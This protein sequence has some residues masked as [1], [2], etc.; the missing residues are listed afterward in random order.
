MKH[1]LLAFLLLTPL[2]A[3][4]LD[5]PG[6]TCG[7]LSADR[8]TLVERG[9]ATAV[10]TDD[11]DDAG[12]LIAADNLRADFRRTGATAV[13]TA[14]RAVIAGTLASKYIRAL[15]KAKKINAKDL[16]GKREKYVI[17]FVKSP[18]A[19]I[20]EALVI[21]GSDKRG[22]IYGIYEL[23]EQLGVSPWY[24][25]A[26]VPVPQRSD[27]AI[28]RGTYTA[29]EPAV[30][31]RGIFLNDEA[32]CLTSWV[33]NTYGTNYGDHRFYARVGELLLRLR[34]NFLWPAMWMWTF[35]GDDPLN[36]ET[37][38]RLGI[39]MGTS[40]HEPMAR[41]HQEWARHRKEYGVW[42]YETNQQVLDRFFREGMERAKNTEDLITVGMRG[43]GDTS[44]SGKE[45]HDDEAANQDEHDIALLTKII[46][47]Q[48]KIIKD[49]TGAAPERRPQVW[50]L[51]KEVQRYYDKGLRVP[52]DVTLL[53]CDDNWG[54]V[55]R[56][57]RPE[58]RK[59]SG[60]FGMY[61]H[62]DYVGAP[63][64]SK[65]LNV[66]PPQNLAEQMRLAYDYGV[67]RL[68]VLNVGDLKPMEYPIT[69]FL[70]MAWN[71]NSADA[72]D[73]TK[74]TR[75]FC[76]Q[77]FGEAQADE[78]AR[79]LNTYAKYNGRVTPE[80]LDAD[81]YNVATGEWQQ[82]AD[83][84]MRLEAEALRQYLSLPAEA[85][86]AYRE[87]VLFPVQAVANLYDMYYAVAMNRSL[88]RAGD[89]ACNQW[90]DRA[91][92]A[93]QRDSVL[94]AAYN[95]DIAAGKWRGMMTQKHIGYKI[96]DDRFPHDVLPE[97]YRIEHPTQAG[98]IHT[99]QNG[100]VA[101]EA[102]HTFARTAPQGTQWT[103]YP[104]M[105]RTLSA[106]ALTP[107]TKQPD[108][109]ELAYK[110]R[111]D[112]SLVA[113]ASACGVDAG[114][115]PR[116]TVP[117]SVTVHIV[118]KSTLAFHNTVGHRYTVGFAGGDMQ[119][120][121]FNYNLNEEP[122]NIYSV[123]YPTVA[124]RVVEKT[125]RLALPQARGGVYKLLLRPLDPAI[126]FEKIVVDLGGYQPQYLFGHESPYTVN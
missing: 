65:W 111:T 116:A 48:R 77:Q 10:L 31:Y 68:W 12:V 105:G 3:L 62:V 33:K 61:Y 8:F 87:L 60:G 112:N 27:I 119:E 51:Y 15:V 122:E 45:G 54:N 79:I 85:H 14:P 118:V 57:P 109:A 114:F 16:Q 59:R 88:Y 63:R 78:A 11:A 49:V 90:A 17:T 26:D 98:F 117:D 75:D 121:N 89:A 19:G 70:D 58:E 83:Q 5:N 42:N 107:Y 29:G 100:V 56:L 66:T 80:M 6:I 36:S 41:N 74:H 124:R 1:A 93:F 94:C 22:T 73:I 95:N 47:N 28:R 53:L 50:A 30:R 2:A 86:D 20:D 25:W 96:W 4:A 35:Y 125:V 7:T 115:S 52:D 84:Y 44:M 21:A 23:S 101:I 67:D 37:M 72:A 38:D 106:L 108:G 97:V 40:H 123:C 34:A 113:Q 92:A 110:F 46:A 126:V 43:D 64:N 69:L 24:D 91:A 103:V 102:E 39:I 32:P 55:R 76:A 82:V 13:S 9:A 104:D 99:A 81:T 71:P 18:A 120:V